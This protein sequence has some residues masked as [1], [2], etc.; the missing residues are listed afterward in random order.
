[1]P[2]RTAWRLPPDKDARVQA[3]L[4]T[5]RAGSAHHSLQEPG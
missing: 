2:M 1:M 5:G 4:A 3:P